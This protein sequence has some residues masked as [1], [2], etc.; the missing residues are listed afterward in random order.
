MFECLSG[1]GV[2]AAALIAPPGPDVIAALSEVD[3]GRLSE[4]G[5]VDLLVALERQSAWLSGFGQPVLAAVGDDAEAAARAYPGPRASADMALRAAHAEIGAALRLSDVAAASRLQTARALTVQLPAV[6][7]ALA[8]GDISFWQAHAIV[9]ATSALSD[10]KARWVAGRVLG[11]ARHQTVGQLR[12]C[13]RRAVLAV[14]PQSAADRARAAHADRSLDWW[15]LPDGMA[16]LRLIASASEV[17]AVYHAADAV[18]HQAQAAGPAPGAEGWTP[19]AGLR[20]DALVQ[21]TTGVR[22]ARPAAAVNVIIDLPTL[23]GLQDN[24]AELA[25]YGPIPAPL[26]RALAA[27]G[28]WRRMILDP[29]TGALLDLGHASYQPSA[30][31]SRFVKTR[32]P[33]C[34]FPTC[35]RAAQRC[36]IDHS[37][38]YSP[39][40]PGGGGTDRANLGPFCTAHH[41]LKHETGW[42]VRRDPTTAHVTWI[43][44]TG[45][46]YE[47]APHDYRSYQAADLPDEPPPDIGHYLVVLHDPATIGIAEA[48]LN[49]PNCPLSQPAEPD[50]LDEFDAW[51]A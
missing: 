14:E 21:L 19:I 33:I 8:A 15:P 44:P 34:A 28:R 27:D 30:A 9:D 40:D 3:L 38:R 12:R 26:A 43:S 46:R 39:H 18:A 29:K 16:E 48:L 1:S 20:A 50:D 5:R 4:S 23:L 17:M 47:S 45:R 36:E 35:N 37:R 25:G 49:D 22:A 41:R 51:A 10:E 32:D 6:H 7:A 13:L 42:T 2:V 31:L 24:P 11:R